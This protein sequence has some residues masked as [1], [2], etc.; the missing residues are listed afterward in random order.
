MDLSMRRLWMATFVLVGAALDAGAQQ[1]KVYQIAVLSASSASIASSQ[2]MNAFRLGLHELGWEEGRNII[3]VPRYADGNFDRLGELA[4]ELARKKVDVIL[5]S[6]P[7]AL[8]AAAGATKTIPIVMVQGPD[9]VVVGLVASLAHPGGNITGL[10][11][12][13]ADLSVKQ[14]EWLNE[15]VPALSRIAV[16][17]NPAN[18]WHAS[19]VKRV[20]DSAPRL[21]LKISTV[22]VR[23]PEDFEP[24]FATMRKERVEAILSLSDP[25]TIDHRA[26]LAD[27][28]A[29][30][31]LPTMHGVVEYTEAGGLASYWPKRDDMFRRAAHYVHRIL[32][33]TR[34]G[35]LPI[36]QPAKYEL[37]INMKTAKA[38]GL[39]IPTSML[40]RADRLI[41]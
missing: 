40:V 26:H 29:A 3:I 5:A 33:G 7:A 1:V 11:S 18:P 31:R 32:S 22:A 38:L 27:L 6:T 23:R 24:A 41:E 34:P 13:S 17:W 8:A 10:T 39:K 30:H 12:L 9:P 15:L 2:A 25:M 28:A 19:A 14:L 36:E 20:Q 21:G 35:D 4:A 16:L 37:V